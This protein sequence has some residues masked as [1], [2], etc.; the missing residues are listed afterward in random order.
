MEGV[1]LPEWGI[2]LRSLIDRMVPIVNEHHREIEKM[3]QTVTRLERAVAQ[4]EATIQ[5]QTQEIAVLR[6][7]TQ[8]NGST[9]SGPGG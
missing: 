1:V 3:R 5:R 8:G 4:Q 2:H 6:A 9:V 7:A